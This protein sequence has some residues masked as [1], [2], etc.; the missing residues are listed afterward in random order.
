[1]RQAKPNLILADALTT[2]SLTITEAAHRAHI[3]APALSQIVNGHKFPR[4]VTAFRIAR[5][6]GT[7]PEALGLVR[8]PASRRGERRSSM[9]T[10]RILPPRKSPRHSSTVQCARCGRFCIPVARARDSWYRPG[11]C[12]CDPCLQRLEGPGA[13]LG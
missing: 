2:A 8:E 3:Q 10:N 1:M 7:T 11:R 4:P 13:R 5:V 12:W 9:K 6:L